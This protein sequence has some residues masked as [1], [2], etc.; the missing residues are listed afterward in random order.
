MLITLKATYRLPSSQTAI[1]LLE[2]SGSPGLTW[3]ACAGAGRGPQSPGAASGLCA[4]Q[5]SSEQCERGAERARPMGVTSLLCLIRRSACAARAAGAPVTARSAAAALHRAPAPPTLGPCE[6]TV[7]PG[8]PRRW[9]GGGPGTLAPSC[10]ANRVIGGQGWS[11]CYFSPSGAL[12]LLLLLGILKY[13][14]CYSYLYFSKYV[15]VTFVFWLL[16][17]KAAEGSQKSQ[18]LFF[19]FW[20]HLREWFRLQTFSFLFVKSRGPQRIVFYFLMM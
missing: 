11:A 20:R 3:V 15:F 12:K 14:S 10:R 2:L 16:G 9:M 17:K 13:T 5:E 8:S 4:L 18:S 7:G 19:F 1:P 6:R